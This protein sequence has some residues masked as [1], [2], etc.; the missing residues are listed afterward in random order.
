L[1]VVL[2]G[3]FGLQGIT[4]QQLSAQENQSLRAKPRLVILPVYNQ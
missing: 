1:S 3:L 2:L 4:R